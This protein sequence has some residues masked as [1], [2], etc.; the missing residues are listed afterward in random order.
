MDDVGALAREHL[1]KAAAADHGRSAHLFLHEGPLRQTIIALTAGSALDEHNAPVA[2]SLQVLVGS[3]RITAASG[4]VD[5]A[6]GRLQAL[7]QERHGLTA[8]E[9]AA[10]LLTAVTET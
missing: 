9:D 5:I 10:V 4:D 8:L 3:V 1:E 6:A 2:G 7:P